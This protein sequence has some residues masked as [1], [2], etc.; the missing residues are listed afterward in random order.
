MSGWT[1]PSLAAAA[2]AELTERRAVWD[3]DEWLRTTARVAGDGVATPVLEQWSAQTL[4]AAGGKASPVLG[5]QPVR[6]GRH[7][8]EFG[9]FWRPGGERWTTRENRRREAAGWEWFHNPKKVARNG[10]WT[11]ST[12]TAQAVAIL[13]GLDPE[14]TEAVVGWAAGGAR[15]GILIGPG[16][17]GKTTTLGG[18]AAVARSEGIPVRAMAVSQAAVREAAE[19]VGDPEAVN[20]AR[21]LT[22][23]GDRGRWGEQAG[24]GGLWTKRRWSPPASGPRS[25]SGRRRRERRC[26][27][28]GTPPR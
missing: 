28:W 1:A 8:P 10:R 3:T 12:T 18:V 23:T 22:A 27:R 17:T 26:W 9:L 16:G 5:L 13:E 11:V 15:G 4:G 19:A 20:I 24:G 2:A 6:V 21:F 7:V 25:S 14:Q